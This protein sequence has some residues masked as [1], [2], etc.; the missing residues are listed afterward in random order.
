MQI[1]TLRGGLITDEYNHI[2]VPNTKFVEHGQNSTEV[3]WKAGEVADR[4]IKRMEDMKH[5]ALQKGGEYAYPNFHQEAGGVTLKLK[6]KLFHKP[7]GGL[8]PLRISCGGGKPLL[9]DETGA[10]ASALNAGPG[11]LIKMMKVTIYNW[12][13]NEKCGTTI[14]LLAIDYD[15]IILMEEALVADHTAF[16]GESSDF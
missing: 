16:D 5:M 11:S 6:H 12:S 4:I 3:F 2:D 1:L 15:R 10:L 13:F 14:D 7:S 9:M 8:R